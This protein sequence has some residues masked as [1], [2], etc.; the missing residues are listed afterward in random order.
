MLNG[1]LRFQYAF[2]ANSVLRDVLLPTSL[3][4][5]GYGAFYACQK[6]TAIS[7]PT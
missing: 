4:S 6:L 7:I 1:L 2:Y 3:V 5:I